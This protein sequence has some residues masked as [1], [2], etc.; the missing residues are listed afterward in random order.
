VVAENGLYPWVLLSLADL[1]NDGFCDLIA[2]YY[3]QAY[4]SIVTAYNHTG[5]LLAGNWPVDVG[6]RE[7]SPFGIGDVDADGKKEIAFGT[8]TQ[9]IFCLRSNGTIMPG[10]PVEVGPGFGSTPVTLGD[11]DHDGDLEIVTSAWREGERL[12]AYHHTGECLF[13]IPAVY[14]DIYIR[15]EAALADLDGDGDL[16][17][18]IP[19]FTR[20]YGTGRIDAFHHNGTPVSGWPVSYTGWIEGEE[21]T[22]LAIG[23]IDG[24]GDNEVVLPTYTDISDTTVPPAE[25]YNGFITAW[26]HNGALV[27]GFPIKMPRSIVGYEGGSLVITDVGTNGHIDLVSV[28]CEEANSLF[29]Q[30]YVSVFELAG[31]YNQ[32]TIEWPMYHYDIQHTGLCNNPPYEPSDPSPP[33]C[34][35]KVNVYASLYWSGGDPDGDPLTYDVY[36]GTTTS[37]PK[38]VS[39]Q[40]NTTFNPGEQLQMPGGHMAGFTQYYWKIVAWDTHGHQTEGPVWCFK[41]AYVYEHNEKH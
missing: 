40:S 34:A 16:E 30:T 19:T 6:D 35:R 28:R 10:W 29:P 3:N 32:M 37:P 15:H 8:D 36:F 23:D 41:T 20:D 21:S 4:R 2:W 38:V 26:H 12:V 14:P 5:E 33:D 27:S 24:D 39:N 18:L 22:N 11:L 13:S 17:V 25:R 1:D 7:A 9:G 31:T